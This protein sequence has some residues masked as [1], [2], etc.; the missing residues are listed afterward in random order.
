M[1]T[2]QAFFVAVVAVS[3]VLAGFVKGMTGLG[4]P[5]VAVG[6]LGLM[7]APAQAVALLLVPS[8]ITNLW[9]LAA[10]T[11]LMALL[12]RLWPMLLGICAGT[13]AGVALELHSGAHAG[14]LL[15]LALIAYAVLG[16]SRVRLALGPKAEEW[17]APLVG[18]CTGAVTAATGV[19]VI[20]SVPYLQAIGLDKD[21]LVQALGLSFT[22][23]TLAIGIALIG[24]GNFAV[25]QVLASSA[26]LA[27]ALAGMFLGQRLRAKV[28]AAVFRTCFFLALLALGV[29][30]ALKPLL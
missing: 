19:F 25:S 15:G 2:S 10:G 16:L 21:E 26:A 7:M 11:N 28:P 29:H 13:A 17:L 1:D 20:P 14:M 12:Q 18:L 30:L 4:L 9:Q 23:S 8:L 5:T 3:F 22:V 24:S 6:L 27:P